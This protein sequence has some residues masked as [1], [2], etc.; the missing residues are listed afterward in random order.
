ML[1]QGNWIQ[2]DDDREREGRLLQVA[3]DALARKWHLAS[4][5][6][7]EVKGSRA[8]EERDRFILKQSR[9]AE[10]P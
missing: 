1:Q 4:A 9:T 10:R 2:N 5:A 7:A 3:E 8:L 6:R